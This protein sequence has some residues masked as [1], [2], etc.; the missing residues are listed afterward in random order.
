[1][2]AKEKTPIPGEVVQSAKVVN[3]LSFSRFTESHERAGAELL[4]DARNGEI[5]VFAITF[6]SASS[7]LDLRFN[8]HNSVVL[9]KFL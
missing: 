9:I 1:M 7:F 6:W 2:R 8:G 4:V 3:K 5:E